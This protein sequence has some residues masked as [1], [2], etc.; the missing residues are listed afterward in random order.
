M[1][2]GGGRSFSADTLRELFGA[3][4]SRGGGTVFGMKTLWIYVGADLFTFG[5]WHTV[6]LD[7]SLI[8]SGCIRMALHVKFRS[9]FQCMEQDLFKVWSRCL[10][11]SRPSEYTLQVLWQEALSLCIGV[12]IGMRCQPIMSLFLF[13]ICC[14]GAV[15][16]DRHAM[17]AQCCEFGDVELL[18][19]SIFI[20]CLWVRSA[21]DASPVV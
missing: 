1:F 18:T 6:C 19:S 11:T 5:L 9:S 14:L 17:P 21:C 3:T 2:E 20:W 10:F 7:S 16:S 12:L 8:D 13:Y 4:Y 15:G